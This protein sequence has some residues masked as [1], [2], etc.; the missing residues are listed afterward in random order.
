MEVLAYFGDLK[1]ATE[2][3]GNDPARADDPAALEQAA[4]RGHQEFVQLLLRHQPDLAT[5]V[6]V[7][8]RREMA[9]FLFSQGMNP[10][11]PNWVRRTPLH[12]FAGSG[13]LEGAALF[14]D[15]GADIHA[16]DDEDRSTPLAFAARQGRLDMVK[17]LL[18][19]GAKPTLPD[20]PP[21]ATPLAWATRRGHQEVVRLL[22]G[23]R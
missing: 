8:R 16:R 13:D 11:R 17:F 15:H 7:A 18:A 21:W 22:A 14:L 2:L 1:T 9:E 23:H 20:D 10:N 12:H 3:L 5:R 4:G 19:R 6:T